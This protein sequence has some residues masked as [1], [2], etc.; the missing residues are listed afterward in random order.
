M[1]VPAALP[2]RISLLAPLCLIGSLALLAACGSS[3]GG[4]AGTSGAPGITASPLAQSV[5]LG[6]SASFSVDATGQS[7]LAYQWLLNSQA[8]A[9]ATSSSY[10]TPPVTGADNG[11]LYAVT[12]SN[13]LGSITTAAARLT[14]VAMQSADVLTYHNDN[15]RSGLNPAE[16]LL[17]PANVSAAGFGLLRVLP[18]DGLVDAQP[19]VVSAIAVAGKTRNVLYVATEHGS[20]YAFDADAGTALLKVSLVPSGETTSDDRGC[21]QVTPEIGITATPVIDK[22]GGVLYAV[23]MSK[24][25]AGNYYQR[26]HALNLTTLTEKP[27]SPVVVQAS[28]PGTGDN[29]VNGRVLFDPAQY[30]ER[31]G[32]V[33]VNGIL[34]TAWASHCDYAPY[35]GWVIGYDAHTLAQTSVLDLVPNGSEGAIWQSGGGLAADSAGNLYVLVA[36]GSFDITFTA[37]G[38]PAQGDYGNAFVK[39]ATSGGLS[40]ADYF[41]EQQDVQESANDTDLGSGAPMLLPDLTDAGGTVRHLAVGAGKDGH[42]YV[43]DRDHMG[44]FN[45]HTNPIWQD[46]ANALPGGIWSAPAYANGTVY[47][48]D[49]N[50]SLK[51]FP[52]SAAKLAATPSSQSA[53]TFAYP[54]ASPSVSSSATANV[55]VWA[56]ESAQG[57][58]AVLHAFDATNLAHELYSSNDAT[59]GRDQ[60]GTGNKFVTPTVANGKVYV[61]TPSGVAVFGLLP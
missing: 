3:S 49:V 18:A 5:A 23:A 21:S 41:A 56:L 53:M 59:G 61:G 31:V 30:K 1:A 11:A 40:V 33:L 17:T 14:V 19:L 15:A 4:G 12:V 48:A 42:L 13:S 36:N 39:L 52:V 32:L 10:L 44:G 26:V 47:Y 34:F 60:F 37:S 50:G 54:G 55:I 28:Y 51:A 27:G 35:T 38:F 58:A 8:I 57:Q 25:G 16:S 7:P 46:L 9:G 2:S 6:Q 24:D 22:A 45:A 43:V 20:L 29:S